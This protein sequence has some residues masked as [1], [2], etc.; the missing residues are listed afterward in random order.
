MNV[1][2]ATVF[3]CVTHIVL[4]M[5]FSTFCGYGHNFV[6]EDSV[7]DTLLVMDNISAVADFSSF[8]TIL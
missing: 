4:W 3:C 1:A 6:R 8:G 2:I 5:L 7:F